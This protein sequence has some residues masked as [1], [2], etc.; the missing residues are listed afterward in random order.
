[1]KSWHGEPPF[2]LSGTNCLDCQYGEELYDHKY[3]DATFTYSD[4]FTWS[5]PP[6]DHSD[7]NHFHNISAVGTFSVGRT[8]GKVNF[9][10]SASYSADDLGSLSQLFFA[11]FINRCNRTVNGY[12]VT[13]WVGEPWNYVIE[14][15]DGSGIYQYDSVAT[16]GSI[17]EN[18]ISF[19]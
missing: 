15:G 19:H 11:N 9:E 7:A 4:N 8:D 2:N 13:G 5:N 16:D 1:M 3:L 17:S 14:T 12:P 6:Q 18:S 10:G